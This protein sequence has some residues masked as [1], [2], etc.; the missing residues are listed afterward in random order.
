MKGM[1][2]HRMHMVDEDAKAR[3]GA[4]INLNVKGTDW[5]LME[6]RGKWFAMDLTLKKLGPFDGWRDALHAVRKELGLEPL[7]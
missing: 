5:T 2:L 7:K 4:G 3:C 1:P 6:Y